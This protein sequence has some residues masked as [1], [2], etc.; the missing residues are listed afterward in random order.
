MFCSEIYFVLVKIE[1]SEIRENYL[2]A[3]DFEG[4]EKLIVLTNLDNENPL[5]I[6][7][8]IVGEIMMIKYE[9][10]PYKKLKLI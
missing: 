9:M 2:L 3:K 4:L 6:S 7:Y 1:I 10:N 8:N 5:I